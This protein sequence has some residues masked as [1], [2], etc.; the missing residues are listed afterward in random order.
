MSFFN[1]S[2]KKEQPGQV[3][4]A[5]AENLPEIFREDFIDDSD[6][7]ER[8]ETEQSDFIRKWP[9]DEIYDFLRKDY[10]EEGCNDALEIPDKAHKEQ[11][12]EIIKSNLDIMFKQV[13]LKYEDTIREIDANL[14]RQNDA[15]LTNIA[16]I[17]TARKEN[18]RSHLEKLEQME[19]DLGNKESYMMQVFN[20]YENGFNRRLAGLSLETLKIEK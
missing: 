3:A 1:F 16:D 18:Y 15:G 5:P 10:S 4:A 17:L 14:K 2:R 7:A 11:K 8:K 13:Q 19:K 6:P 12:L 9:I 20:S